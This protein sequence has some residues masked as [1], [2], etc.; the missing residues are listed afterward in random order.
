MA[1][2]N[3]LTSETNVNWSTDITVTGEYGDMLRPT[4]MSGASLY[5]SSDNTTQTYP[6]DPSLEKKVA[7]WILRIIPL[8]LL[9][10][11][12]IGNILAFLVMRRPFVRHTWMGYLLAA[13]AVV[14]TLV[15]IFGLSRHLIRIYWDIDIRVLHDAMCKTHRFVLYTCQ[16]LGAW[17]L[18]TLTTGRFISIRFPFRSVTWCS[19]GRAKL[20]LVICTTIMIAKNVHLFFT[21]S[22]EE[23]YPGKLKCTVLEEHK[24]FWVVAWPWIALSIYAA[25]PFTAMIIMNLFISRSLRKSDQFRKKTVIHQN[26]LRNKQPGKKYSDTTEGGANV[27]NHETT[28]SMTY[29]LLTVNFVFLITATPS[30]VVLIIEKYQPI[31]D[32]V[33]A[34]VLILNYTNH[35]VNFLLYCVSGH[36]FRRE[37]GKLTKHCFRCR[38]QNDNDSSQ[39]GTGRYIITPHSRSPA[40]SRNNLNLGDA[41]ESTRLS[42][43]RLSPN[44]SRV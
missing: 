10:F 41:S 40:I 25:G 21:Q 37:L 44:L 19:V 33:D 30:F 27:N 28:R 7:D 39:G 38:Q 23:I 43:C 2:F 29:M 15:L 1:N 36:R 5:N 24:E 6:T 35:A 18:V 11:G 20:A 26:G 16:D 34:F 17:L 4:Y 31:P 14:D 32:L 22:V 12:C 3:Y 42:P 8:L 9:I 13:L